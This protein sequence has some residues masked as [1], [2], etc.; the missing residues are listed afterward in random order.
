MTKLDANIMATTATIGC[1][2]ML[3]GGI[4]GMFVEHSETY[5]FMLAVG[6]MFVGFAMGY[7]VLRFSGVQ[8][9]GWDKS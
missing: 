6:L 3:V 8:F 2:L 1:A 5:S 7:T 4:F 9:F